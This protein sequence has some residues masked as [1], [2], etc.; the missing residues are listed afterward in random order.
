LT[1]SVLNG[2]T[3]AGAGDCWAVGFS[4]NSTVGKQPLFEHYT[5]S[6]WAIV[7]TAN[8][9]PGLANPIASY[10]K[11][12]TCTSPGD[13][14]AVGNALNIQG[15]QPLIEHFVGSSWAIVSTANPN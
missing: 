6:S 8:P 13:C 14:W 12:V 2:V 5:G 10:L 11:G 9:S 15:E 7:S 3:C 4:G 1:D